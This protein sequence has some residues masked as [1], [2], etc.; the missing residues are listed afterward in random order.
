MIKMKELDLKQFIKDRDEAWKDNCFNPEAKQVGFGIIMEYECIWD[1]LGINDGLHPWQK[2]PDDL[3]KKY[4]SMYND[5]AEEIVGYRIL[6]E[7]YPSKL[8]IFPAFKRVGD[9]FEGRYFINNYVEWL[10]G[11]ASTPEEL[12]ALLDRV[13]KLDLESFIIPPDWDKRCKEIYEETGLSPDP[14]ELLGHFMR[15][16]CTAATSI[17]GAENFLMLYY[18]A[19]ELFARFSEVMGDVMLRRTKIIDRLCGYS[20]ENRPHGFQFNDDNCCLLTPEMYEVFGYPILKK[21]FD[22]YSPDEKDHRYQHSDSDMGHLIPILARFNLTGVQ[23]GPNITMDLIRPYMP[24]T[25]IDGCLAPLVLQRNDEEEIVR[26]A[27]RD[28]ETAVKN[29]WRGLNVAAA[30]STNYG[31]RLSSLRLIEQVIQNFG[32]YDL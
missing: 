3:M 27:K 29:N 11:N 15:G 31:T 1:E 20:E 7:N 17:M 13:E 21:I 16:P 9:I 8:N 19:P 5:K 24:K 22:Y 6:N 2:R 32:R 18:D 25:R 23:F 10:E 14:I 28:C 12:E 26:Q 4:I 30:G